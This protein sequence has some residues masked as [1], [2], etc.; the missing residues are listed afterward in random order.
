MSK[1]IE[2][3][4]VWII[5]S[6]LYVIPLLPIYISGSMLFPFITGKNFVFRIIVEILFV[7]WIGLAI[8]NP[9]YRPN[10]SPL[11]GAATV[12]I[13]VLFLADIFSPNPSRSFFSIA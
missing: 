1:K 13:I 9:K 6:F 4:Y 8:T 11:I 10:F 7:A 5:K 12:F 2:N 3:W